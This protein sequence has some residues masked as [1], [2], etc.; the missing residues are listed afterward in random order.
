[1]IL[2]NYKISKIKGVCFDKVLGFTLDMTQTTIKYE[3]QGNER[4]ITLE[5]GGVEFESNV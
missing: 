1:M 3:Y 4:I 2:T 5:T